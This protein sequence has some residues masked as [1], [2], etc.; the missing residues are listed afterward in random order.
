MSSITLS[1]AVRANPRLVS[2]SLEKMTCNAQGITVVDIYPSV[3]SALTAKSAPV[4][5][6]ESARVLVQASR[7]SRR[8]Q[9]RSAESD[10]DHVLQRQATSSGL[11][12]N[13]GVGSSSNSPAKKKKPAA[14]EDSY[15][16][17][18]NVGIAMSLHTVLLSRNR[19][20]N[21]LGIVQFRHCVCLSLL[22]NR[23]QT[24]EDCEPL[25]MLPDLQYLSLEYNPV[26]RLPHY[27]AHLLRICSWPQEVSPSTCRLRKLDSSA[28]TTAEVKHAAL[29][30]LRESALLPEL[31]YRM[32]LLA[33]LVD[34]E[35]RQRLHRELRQ[36][37]HVFH[38]LGE[39]ASM[40]LLLERGVAHALSRVGVAGAAH[41]ARQLVRDRRRLCTT[42]GSCSERNSAQPAGAKAPRARIHT[43]VTDK[44][45]ACE[46]ADEK[47]GRAADIMSTT[48]AY[49]GSDPIDPSEITNLSTVSSCSL[50]SDT[51]STHA[52]VLQSLSHLLSSKELD[53]SRRSL[54]RADT[55]EAADT[56]KA[57]SKD[58]FRQTIVSL[59]VH[60]CTLLLRISR[61][62]GQTLTSHDVDRLCEVWLH[63]VSHCA[64]AA[65]AAAEFNAT[66]P[67]RLVVQFG[68]AAA[69][70]K[71][72][73]RGVAEDRVEVK[74]QGASL[75]TKVTGCIPVESVAEAQTSVLDALEK[76]PPSL[77]STLS[78]PSQLDH[79]NAQDV[80][81]ECTRV[82][83]TSSFSN[84]GL[85]PR[86]VVPRP[87]A[88]PQTDRTQL[89]VPDREAAG[90]TDANATVHA[91]PQDSVSLKESAC[92]E[93]LH[94]FEVLARR[95][96]KRRVVQQ[97]C[98]ALRHRW[99]TRI[100]A[101]YIR[102]KVSDGAAAHLRS[103]SWGGLIAQ[104]TYVERKRG[105]FTL[106][107]RRMQLHR[108]FRTRQLRRVWNLFRQKTAAS[109]ILRLRCKQTSALV[110][111]HLLDVAFRTWKFKAEKRASERCT[112]ARRRVLADVPHSTGTLFALAPPAPVMPHLATR[113]PS[114]RITVLCHA[115]AD[116]LTPSRETC[117]TATP[118]PSLTS[119]PDEDATDT[120][121][122]LAACPVITS[123]WR[124]SA[125]RE[126]RTCP[127]H[128]P[129][130]VSV[131][132]MRNDSCAHSSSDEEAGLS[133]TG[134]SL[135]A[136][137]SATSGA[138]T[139]FLRATSPKWWQQPQPVCNATKA[140]VLYSGSTREL[141]QPPAMRILFP[142]ETRNQISGPTRCIHNADAATAQ[143]GPSPP[144]SGQPPFALPG[145]GSSPTVLVPPVKSTSPRLYDV[146]KP[147]CL[148]STTTARRAIVQSLSRAEK[149]ADAPGEVESPYPAADV[150]A[151]V[152]L[153]KQL[154][155]DRGYLIETLR[156][157]HLSRQR[158]CTQERLPQSH[159]SYRV[160]SILPPPPG[161]PAPS[162]TVVEQLE[163]QCASL[164]TEVHRLEKLVAALQ[165]E[166]HQFLE[167]IQHKMFCERA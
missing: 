8:A 147:S 119:A 43:S 162:F 124:P 42:S 28:V 134:T 137:L 91:V 51:S 56:C 25:A 14:N 83:M 36:R 125:A 10:C 55:S 165:D 94:A 11:A 145:V 99:Q 66:G 114:P 64:P 92:V 34:I 127:P 131:K 123:V 61:V 87:T 15:L 115:L 74:Q 7:C 142:S 2:S 1:S 126:R 4:S 100:G 95:R 69:K 122:A 58:A 41:M 93:S 128:S 20:S 117:S 111:Q 132:E 68:T 76:E 98:S 81:I 141:P 57:W 139:P 33:F 120:P 96:C 116:A 144:S 155:T 163:G 101:A 3:L 48:V 46:V 40:E 38:D 133:A 78:S 86:D 44:K 151:L 35:K 104:V 121:V 70:C 12:A 113:T 135:K 148:P 85:L 77:L 73:K 164:E 9:Q 150:E 118:V 107:R 154:E 72:T 63:A 160:D 50:L 80:T 82:S 138:A 37:G 152:E 97:W 23:I 79:R 6:A 67:R 26:T 52:N 140:Q 19:I 105:F 18:F 30:L 108:L 136:G 65:T 13:P 22:G 53:W 39:P 71:T 31:L 89:P 45:G 112:V 32:Q 90:H 75:G 110:A 106:W 103:P 17:C 60:L 102:E 149:L 158:H 29:C 161:P 49:F 157:L 166:R 62:V 21:L 143:P 27:R 146:S 59:D 54:R 5:V 129:E 130:S 16:S 47:C 159:A 88:R 156:S 109:S 167:T 84:A 24:I 153:A